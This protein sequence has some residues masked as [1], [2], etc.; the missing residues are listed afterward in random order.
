MHI[1]ITQY[2]GFILVVSGAILVAGLNW[3][4]I[5]TVVVGIVLIIFGFFLVKQL[6]DKRHRD[7][8]R[9]THGDDDG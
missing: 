4:S 9:Y 6:F 3:L 8:S 5:W 7:D 2:I 1:S